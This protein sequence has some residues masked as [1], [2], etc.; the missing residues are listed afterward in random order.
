MHNAAA[1]IAAAAIVVVAI[2]LVASVMIA[3]K[4]KSDMTTVYGQSFSELP[5]SSL[6]EASRAH[7]LGLA[8][9]PG[10]EFHQ[11]PVMGS[12]FAHLV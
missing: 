9:R 5:H 11:Q 7:R 12:S 10:F 3:S 8:R 6:R 1:A 4:R 2:V